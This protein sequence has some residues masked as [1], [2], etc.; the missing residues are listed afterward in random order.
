MCIKKEGLNPLS[1]AHYLQA[2]L[3]HMADG[4]GK[5]PSGIT[6]RP[7]LVTTAHC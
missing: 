7:R 3:L 6:F 1:G 5:L 2:F 4:E